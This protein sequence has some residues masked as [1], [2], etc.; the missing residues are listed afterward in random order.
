MKKTETAMRS[1]N[2]L[3]NETVKILL[4]LR[5]REVQLLIVIMNEKGLGGRGV[6][7]AILV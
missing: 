4:Q 3:T 7:T 6:V 2:K 5:P 1:K